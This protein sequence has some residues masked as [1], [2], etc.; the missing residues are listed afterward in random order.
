MSRKKQ[1][2]IDQAKIFVKA[3]DGGDGRVSFFR[4]K[5]IP[6]G[7]PD[8]GDGGKGGD[9]VFVGSGHKS[10]LYDFQFKKHFR[11]ENG[12]PGG[13][14]QKTGA[15]GEDLE[16]RVP[17]GTIVYDAETGGRIGEVTR[18]GERWV[19]EA[20]GRGGLGNLHFAS[21]VNR[22][23][24]KA[25]PGEKREGRWVRLELRIL[26][27]VGIV[28]LPNVGKSTLL[29]A[30]SEARPKIADYPF[31]TLSPTLGVVSFHGKKWTMADMPGLIEGAH[32]G[33]GLGVQFLRHIER[34]R[35]LL[36]L[37]AADPN[38][39]EHPFEDF[40]AVRHEIECYDPSLRDRKFLV[41]INKADRVTELQLSEAFARFHKK[42]IVPVAVS[43]K[44]K[45]G[46]QNLM[47]EL[48]AKL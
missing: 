16:L 8:G 24:R 36:Y 12:K 19:A 13:K 6:K 15:D 10:T 9:T 1:T 31:T 44:K 41:T 48:H 34:T 22:T 7:G 30:L 47:K 37:L 38:D 23:P 14:A 29:A 20:G 26:A 21:S 46:L 40:Q 33:T 2:F 25:T 35:V 17:L 3:G 5:F 4:A 32:K 18:D 45:I 42:G 43:A 28:G 27:D 11:A 39:P